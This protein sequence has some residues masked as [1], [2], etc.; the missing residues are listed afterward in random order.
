MKKLIVP[1]VSVVALVVGL[2]GL[3]LP[4]VS[5][6]APAPQGVVDVRNSGS[7]FTTGAD[8]GGPTPVTVNYAG[9]KFYP[10]QNQASWRN[11]TGQ[12]QYVDLA[13]ISTDGTASSTYKFYAYATTSPARTI[14]DWVAP[15]SA[16]RMLINGQQIATSSVA[17]TTSSESIQNAALGVIQVPDGSYVN[18]LFTAVDNNLCAAAKR[19]ETATST[20]RG[21]NAY[22]RLR[23]HN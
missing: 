9:D 3:F 6:Q 12:T 19:C 21:F 14:F 16:N 13:E 22:W 1:I 15:T 5:P 23:Y 7:T 17:T 2:F 11:T 18:L 20:N 4:R 10:R 8:F